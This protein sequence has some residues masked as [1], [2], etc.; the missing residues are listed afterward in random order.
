MINQLNES[1]S[2]IDL[3]FSLNVNL[4]KN[5]GVSNHFTKMSYNIIYGTINLN[6]L[7]PLLILGNHGILKM[8]IWSV[9]K[10]QLTILTGLGVFKIK[11]GMNNEKSPL[12]HY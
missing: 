7:L 1:S 4:M 9:F 10:N 2:C 5:C 6:I 11:I 3:I 12:K 8:Q